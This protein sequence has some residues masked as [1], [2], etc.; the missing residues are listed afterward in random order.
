MMD[1]RNLVG[2]S[3]DHNDELYN[4]GQLGHGFLL[5]EWHQKKPRRSKQK[6]KAV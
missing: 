2:E 6:Y 5:K 4:V 1:K 3:I